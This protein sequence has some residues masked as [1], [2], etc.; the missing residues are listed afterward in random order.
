MKKIFRWTIYL[1]ILCSLILAGSALAAT[2]NETQVQGYTLLE[3]DVLGFGGGEEEA[4]ADFL[5]YINLFYKT[6]L[7]VTIA[8]AIIYIVIGGL[9]YMTSAAGSGKS[10]GKDTIVK[11]IQGLAIALLSYL[12]LY[13]INPELVN[14]E[15]TIPQLGGEP[16]NTSSPANSNIP[17]PDLYR[18]NGPIE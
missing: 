7:Y 4:P 16:T 17:D 5:E 14:W 3:P 12:I 15:I 13:T 8:L 6:L 10:E 9:K 2:D 11:A 18:G 1:L